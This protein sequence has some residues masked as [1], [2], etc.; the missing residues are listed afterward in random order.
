MLSTYSCLRMIGK[1]RN[2]SCLNDFM[3]THSH[4]NY[5]K[6]NQTPSTHFQLILYKP[7]ILSLSFSP[8]YLHPPTHT[9][10]HTHTHTPHTHQIISTEILA[11]QSRHAV[12][13]ARV[14]DYRR[15][16]LDLGHRVLRVWVIFE[17]CI[18][19]KMKI[20]HEDRT[21]EVATL[22]TWVCGFPLFSQKLILRIVAISNFVKYTPLE[23]NPLYGIL[24]HFCILALLSLPMEWCRFS[25]SKHGCL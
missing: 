23:N 12:T 14:E 3:H 15:K 25:R 21:R 9:H 8:F 6:F 7:K 1:S 19:H 4:Y 24:P 11:L 13:S 18:F 10:T 16:L 5:W 2:A 22:G 20:F 17:G